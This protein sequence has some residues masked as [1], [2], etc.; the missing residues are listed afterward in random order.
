MSTKRL[1]I[2]LFF[3]IFLMAS[4]GFSQENPSQAQAQ[5]EEIF[6]LFTDHKS[7]NVGDIVTVH[8]MEFSSGSN[9]ASTSTQK[10]DGVGLNTS[11]S[12]MFSF[13]PGAGMDIDKETEF[14]GKGSTSQKANLRA[15]MSAQITE[16]LPNNNLKIE[17][18]REVN[19]NGDR[20][21]LILRGI[22]RPQDIAANNIIYS[23]NI[24]DAKIEYK[25][26]GTVHN[27]Q[28]PGWFF[29]AINWIF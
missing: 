28:R 9:E 1:L 2:N 18:S 21:M 24:A 7:L 8:I 3:I 20:Q 4:A 19:V 17:G 27:G 15:K 6:S 13:L 11:G 5:P 16:R 22:V 29:R 10:K 12:G 26:K 23:Y 14:K 25:G